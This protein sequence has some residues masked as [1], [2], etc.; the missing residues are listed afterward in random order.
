MK[1]GGGQDV[2]I[3]QV[4]DSLA[5]DPDTITDFQRGQDLIDLPGFARTPT[6]IGAADFAGNGT[7]QLRAVLSGST[8]TVEVD[9]NGDGRAEFRLLCLN[10][11][12]AFGLA[13]FAL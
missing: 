6:F 5:D 10:Q 1:G 7:A 8:V 13:D 11:T 3:F 4:R 2:F 9:V 12:R